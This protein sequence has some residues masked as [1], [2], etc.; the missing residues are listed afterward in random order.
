MQAEETFDLYVTFVGLCML[1]KD[2]KRL[3]VLLPSTADHP[4]LACLL[5][6]PS[7]DETEQGDLDPDRL[8]EKVALEHRQ[9]NLSGLGS[10]DPL[11]PNFRQSNVFDLSAFLGNRRVARRLLDTG[12]AA[13]EPSEAISRIT[14]TAGKIT[15][16]KK[17]A[18]W[19]MGNNFEDHMAISVQWRI[20]SVPGNSL[21]LKLQPLD[22][23]GRE[24]S[25]RLRAIDDEIRIWIY[26]VPKDEIPEQVPRD[27]VRPKEPDNPNKEAL[28][29]GEYY[30]VL[31]P[32]G[33]LP[34]FVDFGECTHYETPPDE[35]SGGTRA[36]GDQSG[37]S[38][39]GTQVGGAAAYV[40]HDHT[41]QG[42]PEQTNTD[43][44][45]EHGHAHDHTERLRSGDEVAC[46]VV[47]ATAAT[48]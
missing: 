44:G 28:H 37:D 14:L 17:G 21:E 29:F 45:P 11:K 36:N 12:D 15:L 42:A 32:K 22:K 25:L 23:L 40:G 33:P 30:N 46:I 39:P 43:D 6:N 47:T 4:H 18:L 16:R 27:P 9:L 7:F 38:Q 31:P 10:P 34:V 48:T 2:G 8:A 41:T 13:S 19:R 1:V 3:H 26:H 35:R 24:H 20:R 5:Y